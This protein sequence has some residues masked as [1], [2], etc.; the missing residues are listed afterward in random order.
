MIT[1][2]LRTQTAGEGAEII[3]RMASMTP[4]GRQA[5]HPRR[6]FGTAGRRRAAVVGGAVLRDLG[7]P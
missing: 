3:V 6:R 1:E 7:R 2:T 5:R 4:A